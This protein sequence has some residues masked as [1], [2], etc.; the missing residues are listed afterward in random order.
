MLFAFIDVRDGKAFGYQMSLDELRESI[1]KII[2]F[3][4]PLTR[5]DFP[6]CPFLDEVELEFSCNTCICIQSF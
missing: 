1:M 6:I 3:L 5:Y 4:S 2:S